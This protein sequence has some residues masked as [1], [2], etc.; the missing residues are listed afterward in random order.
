MPSR[1]SLQR[2]LARRAL[3]VATLLAVSCDGATT[4]PA[5]SSSAASVT[6]S[7]VAKATPATTAAKTGALGAAFLDLVRAQRNASFKIT[8]DFTA[9]T[10]GEGP[11]V[12]Q[13]WYAKGAL[14]RWDLA[15]PTGDRSSVY[16]L[17]DGVSLCIGAE[18]S[19]VKLPNAASAPPNLGLRFQQRVRATPERFAATPRSTGVIAGLEAQCFTLIDTSDSGTFGAGT[20]CYS[21]Q[22]LPLL[23]EFRA[24]TGRFRMTATR[25]STNVSDADFE[26]PARPGS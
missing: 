23:S 18:A 25:V 8:Y 16:F 20:S 5:P 9:G 17:A 14:L 10:N 2:A 19:C 26:L 3:V 4:T 13:T 22:G 15:S 7:P 11:T 24:P 1:R 12:E 21:A 6:A